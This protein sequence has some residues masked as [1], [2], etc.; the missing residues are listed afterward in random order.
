M[1]NNKFSKSEQNQGRERETQ[2]RWGQQE[3]S[4]NVVV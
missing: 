2:N 1:K 4:G 3:V